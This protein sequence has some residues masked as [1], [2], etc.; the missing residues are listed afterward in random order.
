MTKDEILSEMETLDHMNI[1]RQI[2]DNALLV[3]LL[4]LIIRILADKLGD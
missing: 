1:K 3:M 2:T 4:K